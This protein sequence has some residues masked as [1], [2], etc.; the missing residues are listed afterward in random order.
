[1]RYLFLLII[2]FLVVF[3]VQQSHL[4]IKEKVM[5]VRLGVY[6]DEYHVMPENL[7]EYLVDIPEKVKKYYKQIRQR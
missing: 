3:V 7:K 4:F 1:M 2:I 6:R 5:D